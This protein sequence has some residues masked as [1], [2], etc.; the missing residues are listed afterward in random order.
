[1]QDVSPSESA[2]LGLEPLAPQELEPGLWR[3]PMPLPFPLHSANAYLLRGDGAG[4]GTD[5]GWLLVDAPLATAQALD[6]FAA[7]L[8]AAGARPEDIT[9]LVLTHAHPDHIG[10]LGRWQRRSGAPVHL[11]GREAHL[12]AALWDDPTHAAFLE[13]A[14]ALARHGMPGDEAQRLVTQAAELRGMLEPPAHVTP[15]AH[16]QRLRLAGG[17]YHAVWTPGHADGHLCL[18]RDDGL[19]LAGDHA[20]PGMLPTIGR[21]PWSR[22]DPVGDHLGALAAVATLPVRLVL[23]GHGQPYTDLRARA[24]ELQGAHIRQTAAVARLLAES[25]AAVDAY[26]L[27]GRLYAA[28]WR[29]AQS[30][31][32]AMAEMVARLEHLRA[33]GRAERLAA[34]DGA[35]TYARATEALGPDITSAWQ[36]DAASQPEQQAS[37]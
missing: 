36:N 19:F 15:I 18:L 26:E 30:R 8:D 27:A 29:H 13:A 9:A 35:V 4:G 10:T 20:L 33:L 28:R 17:H 1:M 22:P 23:S 2:D 7:G 24:N 3:I 31:L 16:G 25:G 21:Y 14:H 12:M 5:E 34:S 32:F 11:L 37:A 6:A